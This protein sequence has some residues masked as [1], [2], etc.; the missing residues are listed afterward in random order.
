ME[1]LNWFESLLCLLL[2]AD[3]TNFKASSGSLDG[4]SE[5]LVL[6]HSLASFLDASGR[7]IRFIDSCQ[8]RTR[9]S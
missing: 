1:V 9:D 8:K 4:S 2:A 3:E 7:K 5:M 6:A